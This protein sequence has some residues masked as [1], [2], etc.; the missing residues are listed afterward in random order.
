[1]GNGQEAA[2]PTLNTAEHGRDIHGVEAQRH[3]QLYIEHEAMDHDRLINTLDQQNQLDEVLVEERC[4]RHRRGCRVGYWLG[5]LDDRQ[6]GMCDKPSLLGVQQHSRV[7]RRGRKQ[8]PLLSVTDIHRT[9]HCSAFG[10][11]QLRLSKR[12][13]LHEGRLD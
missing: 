7:G 11:R 13:T 5:K 2:Q 6:G 1:V 4:K 9:G 3:A 12:P 8:G 10:V